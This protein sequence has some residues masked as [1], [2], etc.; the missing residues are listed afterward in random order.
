MPHWPLYQ[1]KVELPEGVSASIDDSDP[2]TYKIEIS[3]PLGKVS[4]TFDK[5]GISIKVEGNKIILS[6]ENATRKHKRVINCYATKIKR[7]I[8]G[9]TKGW[10]YKMKIVYKHFPMEVKVEGDKLRIDNYMG[11]R[12]PRY[13]KILPGVQ[14][15]IKKDE[16]ILKGIDWEAVGQTAANIEQATKPY[17]KRDRRRFWDG[18]Y[19]VE[20]K[21]VGL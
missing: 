11:E 6:K 3:G 20:K 15:E 21:I 17:G 18:I 1:K 12:V 5:L 2:L 4:K 19:I 7:M 9:V 8:T 16:I 13:A 10:K 14:V